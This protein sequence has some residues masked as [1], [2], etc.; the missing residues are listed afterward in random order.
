MYF[1]GMC[2]V[3]S[4]ALLRQICPDYPLRQTKFSFIQIIFLIKSSCMKISPAVLQ[5]NVSSIFIGFSKTELHGQLKQN[6][7]WSMQIIF[8][9]QP[10]YMKIFS[11]VFHWNVSNIFSGFT[12]TEL[13]KLSHSVKIILGP[14]K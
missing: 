13:H 10:S 9:I 2:P 4:V 14:C 3:S 7:S 12:K 8:L 5:W 6:N 1:T 11:G